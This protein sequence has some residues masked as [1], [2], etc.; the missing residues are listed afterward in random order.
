[1][2][3]YIKSL[4]SIKT[5]KNKLSW[6][7]KYFEIEQNQSRKEE[8][9]NINKIKEKKENDSEVSIKKDEIQHKDEGSF[10][11]SEKKRRRKRYKKN[12]N[13][14]LEI[15]L[16]NLIAQTKNLLLKIDENVT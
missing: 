1:M 12:I 4:F 8:E 15:N 10:E 6:K 11:E 7:R 5:Y 14:N 3:I 9:D 13:K 16:F 2:V